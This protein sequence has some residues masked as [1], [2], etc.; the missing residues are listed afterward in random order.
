MNHLLLGWREVGAKPET[1]VAGWKLSPAKA[2]QP[3]D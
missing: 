2:P 1:I 3:D